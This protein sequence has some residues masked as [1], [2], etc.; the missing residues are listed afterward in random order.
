MTLLKY[1]IGI[2]GLIACVW[3][4]ATSPGPDA[5][6]I[7]KKDYA[8]SAQM[9]LAIYYTIITIVAVVAVVLLF[10]LFQL[11][12][13]T[14]KT[15]MSIIGI[16][17]ALVFFLIL[18]M[19]GSS[20]TEESLGLVG[21]TNQKTINWVSA[22]IYTIIIGVVIGVL[23]TRIGQIMSLMRYFQNRK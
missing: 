14:K 1:V 2:I 6:E 23:A 12:T 22:G 3:V 13:N 18:W 16:I 15:A 11:V 19:M 8:D 21:R 17:V 4:L 7:T 5:T 10:F 9:S 20:D